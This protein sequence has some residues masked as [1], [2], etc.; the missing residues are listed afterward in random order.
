MTRVH[1]HPQD[2]LHTLT[3]SDTHMIDLSKPQRAAWATHVKST[4]IAAGADISRI[5]S[6]ATR[7]KIEGNLIVVHDLADLGERTLHKLIHRSVN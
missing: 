6:G 7:I 5:S 2:A 4:L 1:R 3:Y